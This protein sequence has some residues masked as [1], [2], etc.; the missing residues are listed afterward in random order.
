MGRQWAGVTQHVMSACTTSV[1]ALSVTLTG[2]T[3][4]TPS[5]IAEKSG[6][7]SRAWA[8]SEVVA[9][10]RYCTVIA[11]GIQRWLVGTVASIN[12]PIEVWSLFTLNQPT[13]GCEPMISLNGTKANHKSYLK[14]VTVM[15]LIILAALRVNVLDLGPVVRGLATVYRLAG[16]LGLASC[17]RHRS[18]S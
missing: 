14:T 5:V 7:S 16:R 18:T 1:P 2:I 8:R 4:S 3:T 11:F 6:G 13:E 17:Y 15:T 10:S 9:F 12:I